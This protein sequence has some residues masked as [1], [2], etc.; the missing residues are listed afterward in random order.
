M[1]DPYGLRKPAFRPARSTSFPRRYTFE[2]F[3]ELVM[4]SSGFAS[5]TM[6]SALLP[7]ATV[8]SWS[9]FRI[10]AAVLVAAVIT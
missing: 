7:A 2:I 3:L 4:L 5:S 8:P 1:P 10:S 6:K 9:I